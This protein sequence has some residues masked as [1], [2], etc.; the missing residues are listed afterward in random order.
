MRVQDR[1][2][3]QARSAG[4]GDEQAA[5]QILDMQRTQIL[6]REITKPWQHVSFDRNLIAL[7]VTV[8]TRPRA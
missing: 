3:R 1:P 5:V 6:Q 8:L 2:A 7:K 4:G